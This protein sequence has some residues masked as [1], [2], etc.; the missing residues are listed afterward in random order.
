MRNLQ[1]FRQIKNGFSECYYLSEDEAL[2]YNAKED[3]V[4]GPYADHCYK[5]RTQDNKIKTISQRSLYK[6]VYNKPFCYFDS[7]IDEQGQEWKQIDNTSYWISNKGRIK[8]YSYSYNVEKPLSQSLNRPN[9]YYRVTLM[10]D[11]EKKNYYIH[12]LV[13]QYFIQKPQDDIQNY[14]V[15][16]LDGDHKNNTCSNLKWVTKQEHKQIH[17]KEKAIK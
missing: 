10:I 5:L 16:H 17:R 4:K 15:H 12:R 1:N 2:V 3:W 7:V 8:S 9:G 13:A 11:G 6:L 14:Q